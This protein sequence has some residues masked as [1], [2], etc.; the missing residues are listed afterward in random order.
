[1]AN[2]LKNEAWRTP[3]LSNLN[4][5]Y[6]IKNGQVI[7]EPILMN[8]MQNTL[9]L[10]GSQG[11]DMNLNYK[12]NATVPVSAI[13]S[14]ATD[15]LSK[16]PGGSNVKNIRITGLIGGTATSPNVSL[17]IADMAS[18]VVASVTQVVKE[19]VRDE[20]DKQKAVIMAEAEK[21][22]DNIR[23]VAKQSANR[24]RSEANAAAD[25]LEN[26]AKNPIQKVAA[27][28][29]ADKLRSEGEANAVKV[30]QEAEKQ[31]AAIMDEARRKAD[32]I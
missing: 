23:N 6:E 31:I 24:L 7:V 21:Q 29:A 14:G 26:E 30:E 17:G 9:E 27:K 1:M 3:T 13:G 20:V 8:V 32:S 12:V 4:I 25:R 18:S 2:M 10:S 19:Q 5:R 28:V 16:I 15:L 11:L 22:A